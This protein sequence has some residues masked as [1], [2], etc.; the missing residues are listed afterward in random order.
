[1][2]RLPLE[3]VVRAIFA[4]EWQRLLPP[5]NCCRFRALW[6][7]ASRQQLPIQP[8]WRDGTPFLVKAATDAD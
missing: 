7:V 2:N 5:R 6:R 8:L 1:M 4:A 3:A